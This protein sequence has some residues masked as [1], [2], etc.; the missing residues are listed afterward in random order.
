MLDLLPLLRA[1]RGLDPADGADAFH[2][3]FAHAL[4]EWALAEAA[5]RGISTI[6]LSGGCFAN[7]VLAE[8]VASRL[9]AAGAEPL[10]SRA[11]PTNDGG[12]S[13]GQAFI[14]ALRTR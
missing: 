13:V 12:L 10:L 8:G 14:A 3:T 7:R 1:I 4:A 6:A 9:R 5:I 2:G 11:L